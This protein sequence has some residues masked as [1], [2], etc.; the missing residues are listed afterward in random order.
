MKLQRVHA[1][2]EAPHAGIRWRTIC[3]GCRTAVHYWEAYADME[4]EPFAAYY[5]QRCA[6]A[7]GQ[8]DGE[9]RTLLHG[10]A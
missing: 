8:G 2:T 10:V 3:N 6:D 9:E 1:A 5:C 4:G 7:V